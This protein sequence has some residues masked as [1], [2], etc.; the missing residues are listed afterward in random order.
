MFLQEVTDISEEHT[1]FIFSGYSE[2]Y[3]YF[4]WS[5]Q[6]NPVIVP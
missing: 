3:F 6:V 2:L 1:A 4:A 5:V